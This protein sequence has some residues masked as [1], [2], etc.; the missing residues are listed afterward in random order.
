LLGTALLTLA[1]SA[2]RATRFEHAHLLLR[3][4]LVLF[5]RPASHFG[6]SNLFFCFARHMHRRHPGGRRAISIPLVPA[7]V[8]AKVDTGLP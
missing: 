8:H 6:G 3:S 5:S 7:Q 4:V 2:N 1:I